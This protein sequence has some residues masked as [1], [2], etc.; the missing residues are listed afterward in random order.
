MAKD[1][2]NT[3]ASLVAG[4]GSKAGEEPPAEADPEMQAVLDFVKGRG[5]GIFEAQ[6]LLLACSMELN[7]QIREMYDEADDE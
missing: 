1:G 6:E 7:L 4:G 2:L 5:H 3:L